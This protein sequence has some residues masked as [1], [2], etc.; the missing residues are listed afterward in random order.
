MRPHFDDHSRRRYRLEE[1]CHIYLRRLQMS[2]AQRLS[3]Q[4]QYAVGAPL[5][6]QIHSH[7][8]TVEIGTQLSSLTR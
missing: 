3:L 8:Q 4:T 7:R 1:L 5:V 6:A 2:F